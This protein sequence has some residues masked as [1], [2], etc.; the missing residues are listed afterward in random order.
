MAGLLY[1]LGRFAAR[2]RWLV[3]VSW[4]VIIALAA[5]GYGLFRGTISSSVS[6][7]GTATSKVTDELTRDF[8]AASGGSGTLV[9]TTE[10]GDA[11][12]A[13]QKTEIGAL[14]KDIARDRGV[15]SAVDPFV[16]QRKLV[17]QRT[18]AAD[19]STKIADARKQ[20]ADA[21]AQLDSGRKQLATAQQQVDDQRAQ[22]EA[23]GQLAAAQPHLDTQQKTLDANQKKLDDNAAT[24]EHKQQTLTDSKRLLALST[25]LRFVSKDGATAIGTLQFSTPAIEL[26]QSL[27]S[28]IIDQAENADIDG[29]AVHASNDIAQSM[30]AVVGAGEIAGIVIAAIVLL[31]MLGTIV[32]AGLPLISALIGVGVSALGALAFSG[33]VEFMSA[34]P[35]LGLMLGLA[36]G[37][38]YSLFIL[39]RHRTQLKRG[40]D[41]HESIGLANGTSGNAVVFAGATVI[42][43]LLAL[44]VTGIPFLGLMGT[45][46]AAAVAVAILVAVTFTPAMLSLIG[47]RILNKKERGTIG[48]ADHHRVPQKPMKT[49]RAIVTLVLGVAVL[50]VIALPAAQMRLNLPTGAS[51]NV[52]TTQYKAYKAVE[53]AFGAG[54]NGPL[55]VVADLPAKVVGDDALLTQEVAIGEKIADHKHV[56][57]VVPIGASDDKTSIAFQVIPSGGPDSE[58][59]E[60]L[61]HSLRDSSPISTDAGDVKLGVAGNASGAIDVSEKLGQALPLYLLVVVGLSLII[62]IIVFRSILVPVTATAG[63]VLSLL[64]T[65]GGLTAIFQF[66]WLGALFGVHD[67]API[68]SFLPIIMVGVLFGLAMDYQLFLVSGMREAHVHGASARVAVQRGL[69]AGRAVVT[70]A[71][72]IMISVFAGFIFA[73][74]AMIKPIGFGLAFGVLV[75]AFVVRMLLIPAAMHLLG[76][77]AWWLP[78]WLDRIIP[79]VDVEGAKLE[80]THPVGDHAAPRSTSRDRSHSA[81]PE[82]GLPVAGHSREAR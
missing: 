80:R 45:V 41:V 24:L 76:R 20:L 51:E 2:R 30:P 5:L 22:A 38:D 43:A 40:V 62:L 74:S 12:T 78:K 39:N 68:L 50:G 53:D 19:G 23:S 54:Q 52:D 9:F 59:T 69:H 6:I 10:N 16:N 70:A 8:S 14:L 34:T 29:V 60:Q 26:P 81:T 42:I 49:W 11:F 64:A 46:G 7:P 56:V 4:I 77:A 75:D 3:I 31:V 47:P 73:D 44:N 25:D 82:K 63:F 27:K 28:T 72:I 55:V 33:V 37:I 36:V 67:P 48:H 79:D 21:Q 65:F 71:A 13:Q 1:R 17:D 32:G 57:T 61:V 18:K 35:T 58:S 15:D 66:G